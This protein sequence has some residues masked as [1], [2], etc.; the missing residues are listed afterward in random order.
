MLKDKNKTLEFITSYISYLPYAID[1]GKKQSR[2]RETHINSH[3][4]TVPYWP[5]SVPNRACPSCGTEDSR[6][7]LR[8]EEEG[9][10]PRIQP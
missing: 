5:R 2:I 6:D 3:D 1:V 7:S 9:I 8:G 4:Q 10:Q